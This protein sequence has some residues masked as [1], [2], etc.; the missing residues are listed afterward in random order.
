[1]A[2]HI[3]IEASR[4][5]SRASSADTRRDASTPTVTKCN[6]PITVNHNIN[7]YNNNNMTRHGHRP[8]G[9]PEPPASRLPPL[10]AR[11]RFRQM[12]ISV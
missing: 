3:C 8:D 9:P 10:P 4:H 2:T 12:Y 11:C 6:R 7:L 5:E 1:M